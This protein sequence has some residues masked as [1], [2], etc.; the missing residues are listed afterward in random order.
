MVDS[1]H[2]NYTCPE[3]K[4]VLNPYYASDK[5]D[6]SPVTRP[7]FYGSIELTFGRLGLPM[8]DPEELNCI[9][10]Q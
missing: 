2:L 9:R 3:P 5:S 8:Q 6:R 10:L 4:I 1:Q 7:N